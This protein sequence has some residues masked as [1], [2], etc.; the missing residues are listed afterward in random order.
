MAIISLQ[1]HTIL[2]VLECINK[3]LEVIKKRLFKENY[4]DW[5]E[6]SED[7]IISKCIDASIEFKHLH[8]A[9][10]EIRQSLVEQQK[11]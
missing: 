1:P 6:Y 4:D 11:S 7:G 8:L 2:P 3:R 9:E 5:A 10:K